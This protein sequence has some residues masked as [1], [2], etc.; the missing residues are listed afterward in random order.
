MVQR[1]LPGIQA[2]SGAWI[3]RGEKVDPLD[4][5]KRWTF[6]P[7]VRRGDVVVA[8]QAIREVAETP[9]VK[10]RVLIPPDVA[11][12]VRSVVP[13]GDYTLRDP[14]AV[15]ETASGQREITML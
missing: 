9:L 6:E 1:P 5:A 4:I 8:G 14:V 10:H 2:R 11:G 7:L 12:A 13:K 15:V 3:R